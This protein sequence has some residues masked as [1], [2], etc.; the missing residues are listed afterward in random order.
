MNNFLD[1]KYVNIRKLVLISLLLALEIVLRRFLSIQ[2]PIMTIGLGFLPIVIVAVL[3][4]PLAAGLTFALGDF[5]GVM[6]FPIGAFFPGFTLTAFLS[7]VIYGIFLH[8]RRFNLIR[9]VLAASVISIFLM[10]FLNTLW[11][12]MIRGTT[13]LEAYLAILVERLI[14]PAVMIPIQIVTIRF[15]YLYLFTA[16]GRYMKNAGAASWHW[17]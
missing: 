12:S 4:G 11:I 17:G 14:Q 5:I 3:Y 9:V 16:A 8:R 1:G 15:I 6:L 13:T 2:T 10:L 7:G